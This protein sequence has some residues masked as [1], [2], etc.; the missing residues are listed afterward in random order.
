LVR[1]HGAGVTGPV[2]V[3]LRRQAW[4]GA[5]VERRRRQVQLWMLT[6]VTDRR[7]V[8]RICEFRPSL[9]IHPRS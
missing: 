6:D 3:A 1:D 7:A 9:V 4:L 8:G 2:A 5:L